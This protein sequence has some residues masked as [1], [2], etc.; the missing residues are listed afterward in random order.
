MRII[1]PRNPVS[2]ED[3]VVGRR[4]VFRFAGVI[5]SDI[6]CNSV[7]RRKGSA[8]ERT[9][10][11]QSVDN[12]NQDPMISSQSMRRLVILAVS[13]ASLSIA[14]TQPSNPDS[15]LLTIVRN[16]EGTPLTLDAAKHQAAMNSPAAKSA[17]AI[18]AAA[19]GTVRRESGAFDPNLFL[20]WDYQDQE[21]PTASFFAGATVLH[22]TQATGI[23]SLNW[24]LPIGTSIEASLN[25]LRLNTNSSFAFLSPQ[26]NSLGSLTLRQP[27]LGGFWVSARKSLSSA[28]QA[29]D[30]AHSRLQQELLSVGTQVEQLY[31]DLYAGERD[32]AVQKL[33]RDQAAA[34]LGDTELRAKVG[35]VGP[36][37]VANARTFLAEQELLL[38]DREEQ[39]DAL[40][41]M[42]STAIGVR[43]DPPH[44]R[45]VPLDDPPADYPVVNADSLV[46]EALRRNLELRAAL[47]DIEA[48]RTIARAASWE[49][50]PNV[51]LVGSLG[52]SGLSG[53]AHDVIFGSDTLRTL[54]TGSMGDALQQALKRDFPTWR[55][56]LEV[57]IPIGFRRGWGEQDRADAE[58][59]IAEQRY[60]AA[61]RVLD[62]QIRAACRE[63]ANGRKRLSV[64]RQ[65]VVAAEEQVRIGRIEF[66]NGRT[67]AFELVR[68]GADFALAQ[69]RYSQALV[70]S[71]KSAASLRQLTSGAFGMPAR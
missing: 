66:Q 29:L 49:A 8:G 38:L 65:G 50:L 56:G 34:F 35:L 55:V 40:S 31:W 14:Q 10:S 17:E 23:A 43:P 13:T 41:D 1:E 7:L 21:Q 5:N 2:G 58:V 47:A 3:M 42:L 22:T 39:L 24:T 51:D 69:Q 68:L 61:Q 48:R 70:R 16:L 18:N 36:N 27:L 59:V 60:T 52:G 62:A 54:V 32:Y 46:Q 45:F 15:A 26:Y 6:R 67:T 71:A 28:E 64:A 30:A 19:E 37:Q 12:P 44:L 20:S 11:L 33:T 4:N 53:S 25:A 9:C 63:M 57:T